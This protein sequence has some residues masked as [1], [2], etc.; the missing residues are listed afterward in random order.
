MNSLTKKSLTSLFPS[1]PA[2]LGKR[3]GVTSEQNDGISIQMERDRQDGKDIILDFFPSST[4]LI[5]EWE[6]VFRLPYSPSMTDDQRKAR[7][8]AAWNKAA[9]ATYTLINESYA[10]SGIPVVARPL[11]A[12]EDPRLIDDFDQIFV[13]GSLGNLY[14]NYIGACGIMGCGDISPSSFC[15][16]FAGTTEVPKTITIPDDNRYWPLIFVL[17]DIGGGVA[18]IPGELRQ[19]YEFLTWKN[20]PLFMWG[21]SRADYV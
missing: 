13:N 1:G 17:E 11:D 8:I 5:A 19:A 18:Q 7:L 16:A 21:I 4:A 14:K 15:G 3:T 9:V 12:G 6:Y 20:K 2:W 10:L